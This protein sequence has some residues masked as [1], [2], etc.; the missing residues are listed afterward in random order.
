MPNPASEPSPT[1]PDHTATNAGAASSNNG[2][3]DTRRRAPG[4]SGSTP[5]PTCADD[6]GALGAVSP[7]VAGCSA[8]PVPGTA[9]G[10]GAASGTA[11]RRGPPPLSPAAGGVSCPAGDASSAPV[12]PG[13]VAV[14]AARAARIVRAL[15]A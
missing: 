1:Q 7:V 3:R 5:V 6:T 13:T 12:S 15:L 9:A 4:V 10:S 8:G 14:S 11:R 2:H